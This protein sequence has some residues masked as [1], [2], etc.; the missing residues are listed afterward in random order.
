[1]NQENEKVFEEQSE[2]R[3][4]RRTFEAESFLIKKSKESTNSS[5]EPNSN[6]VLLTDG[7]IYKP[8]F[9]PKTLTVTKKHLL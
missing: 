3:F 9:K 7:N 5:K 6:P 1:M 4:E 8:R 2:N